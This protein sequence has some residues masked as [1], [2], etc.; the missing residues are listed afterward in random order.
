MVSGCSRTASREP[1]AASR[2]QRTTSKR[3]ALLNYQTTA[4]HSGFGL[5]QLGDIDKLLR[6]SFDAIVAA[7]V[8]ADD[9][10]ITQVHAVKRWLVPGGIPGATF[11]VTTLEAGT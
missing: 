3:A 5:G 9:S 11:A 1:R 8:I 10:L 7:G 4:C 2:E 6:S